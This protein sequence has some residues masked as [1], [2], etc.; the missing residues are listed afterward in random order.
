MT[1]QYKLDKI[2]FVYENIGYAHIEDK[3]LSIDMFDG[4]MEEF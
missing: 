1:W 4:S 3:I 2:V